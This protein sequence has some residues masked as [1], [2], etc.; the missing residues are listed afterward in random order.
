MTRGR[1]RYSGQGK[2]S[3][4]ALVKLAERPTPRL[5]KLCKEARDELFALRRPEVNESTG[6]SS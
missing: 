4:D 3:F 5:V 6:G 1:F 2:L